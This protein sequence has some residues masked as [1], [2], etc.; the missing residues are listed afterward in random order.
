MIITSNGKGCISMGPGIIRWY[1]G[2][3]C[4]IL[5]CIILQVTPARGEEL[6]IY[7]FHRPPYYVRTGTI[8]KGFLMVFVNRVLESSGIKPVYVEIPPKRILEELKKPQQACSPGW[9]KTPDRERDYIFSAPI[10]RDAPL[11]FIVRKN[12]DVPS[13]VSLDELLKF[14]RSSRFPGLICGFSYGPFLD[15]VFSKEQTSRCVGAPVVNVVKM[16][17]AGRLDFT[18][19]FPEEFGYIAKNY[20]ELLEILI[21]IPIDGI[22]EGNKRYLMCSKGLHEEL[23]ARINAGIRELVSWLD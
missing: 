15:S 17:A 1:G 10:Y 8:P 2:L 20:P 14:L 18:I 23:L 13:K 4:L 5:T 7:Y 3:F 6:T 16:V 11:T 19:T 12:Q 21:T 9:F 22:P